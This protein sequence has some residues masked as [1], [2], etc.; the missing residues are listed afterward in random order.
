M[1]TLQQPSTSDAYG[2]FQR[3]ASVSGVLVETAPAR[4]WRRTGALGGVLLATVALFSSQHL[5]LW[6]AVT[7]DATTGAF[8][9]VV[10][11]LSELEQIFVDN[12][13][14]ENLREFLHD[15]AS[16]PHVCGSKQD[17]K[18]AVYTKKQWESFGIE[19]EI[20]EYYTLLSSPVHRRVA[21]LAPESAK[22][23]LNLT[24]P[25]IAGDSCTSN[26]DALPPFL[27][28]AASGNVTAS[29][30]Y[31]N[32]GTQEDFQ[33]LLDQ[34]ITLKGKIALS[35]YGGNG[36]GIK[37]MLA[38]QFGM[39]GVLIYSDPHEDGFGRGETYPNGPWR[40]ET[41]FQRGS[42]SYLS[43]AA[44]DP[45]TP[46]W[47]SIKDADRLDI[48]DVKSITTLPVLPLSYGQATYLLK[49]IGGTKAPAAWQ[50]ALSL[51]YNIGDDD[52]TI[53]NL[54]LEMDNKVMPIWD[55]IGTIKGNE[56]PKDVVLLGNH[57]DAWVCGAVDP[58]SGSSALME[59]ARGFGE[60][61]KQG[62]KPRRTVKL[63]SWDG[64]EYAL[65]GSTEYAEDNA[66]SLKKNA[67]AYLNVDM[68]V[69]H[70][71]AAGGTPS[72]AKFLLDTAKVTPPNNYTGDI[73]DA[74]SLHDQWI[75]Q[76]A[77]RLA[78]N[79]GRA[80]GM[81]APDY[82]IGFLGSGSDFTPFFQ[83]LGI[84]SANMAFVY[85]ENVYGVYH[86][87]MD[88]VHYVETMSDPKFATHTTL[89]QWWGLL[90]LRLANEN[91]LPFQFST[92]GPVMRG[93]LAKFEDKTDALN[94]TLNYHELYDAITQFTINAEIF[95]TQLDSFLEDN[96]TTVKQQHAW[97]TKLKLLEREFL[98]DEGLPHRP[99]YKHVIFGPGYYQLYAGTAFPGISD[100]IA[101]GD[102]D[103]TI[104]KH[105]DKIARVVQKAGEFLVAP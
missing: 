9:D 21:I 50:G 94:L 62:W 13:K 32:Y 104:Q 27:A 96:S 15:Y 99:W 14:P 57:R 90:A 103:K 53:L 49:A 51:T 47:A 101:F 87:S 18:T 22:R 24:E 82:L 98:L 91:V 77:A 79:G 64:E 41:S 11:P 44:G 95:H 58:S 61:L 2:T 100:G 38:E 83:H 34:N 69:G 93:D 75:A 73:A 45:T 10:R 6:E 42:I 7:S 65:L 67:V 16:V 25:A 52:A 54:D 89:T 37:V 70:A 56:E 105:V 80:D 19:T 63:A 92:Y 39:I 88:S 1:E 71:V 86:S 48:E 28:Y 55:V 74:T 60:L 26:E 46:G 97:N 35:R 5:S 85:P 36:R 29:V 102:D 84:A 17:Y 4:S 31:V 76:E 72:I 43:M 3:S 30:V 66:E 20:K 12:V 81:L 33:W 78:V 23:E 40:P 8:I 68:F 59:L